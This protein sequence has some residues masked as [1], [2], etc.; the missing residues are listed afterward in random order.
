VTTATG[1]AA[2]VRQSL[3]EAPLSLFH[4][5]NY[6]TMLLGAESCPTALRSTGH[7][8]SA[9][10]AKIGAFAGAL[11]TPI[12]LDHFGLRV[13]TLIAGIC[14]L[15]GIATTL[16]VSEPKDRALGELDDDGPGRTTPATS[17]AV[18]A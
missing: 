11:I 12:A 1:P 13:V 8:L 6:T 2:G 16:V 10:I 7:G 4:R 9:G 17:K 3:D 18:P 5:P 14:F 15:L